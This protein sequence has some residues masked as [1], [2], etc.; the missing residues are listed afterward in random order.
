MVPQKILDENH[1]RNC[2]TA[3]DESGLTRTQWARRNGIDARSLHGWWLA[4]G[5][6]D[7]RRQPPLRLVELLP[8]P[9]PSY[10]IHVGPF[11]VEVGQ[12]FEEQSLRRLL[13]LVASC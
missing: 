3:A 11:Q 4:L 7:A 13:Q 5:R 10:K 1:A 9:A 12:P 2:I 8:E 6:K